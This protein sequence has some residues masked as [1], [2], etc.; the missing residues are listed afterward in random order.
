MLIVYST[1]WAQNTTFKLTDYKNPNYFYQ[2]LDL[3]FDLNSSFSTNKEKSNSITSENTFSMNSG[4]GPIYARYINTA[5]TQTELH[6]K[7]DA[8]I[9]STSHHEKF[10]SLSYQFNTA[11]FS[12]QEGLSITGLRRY[13]NQKQQYFEI[14]GTATI[15][16]NH[17]K[18]ETNNYYYDTVSDQG[19]LNLINSQ[20][21][22]TFL[23]GK[24]RIEQV[25]DARL[26]L[27][28]LDDLRALN[29]EKRMA[30]DEEILA[31]A[32]EIT[33]LKYKRFFDNRLRKI[34]EITAI[35][36]FLQKN[37]LITSADATYFTSLNDNW[38]YAN[39]PVRYSGKRM[40]TGVD[41][42]FKFDH[43]KNFSEHFAPSIHTDEYWQQNTLGSLYYVLGIDYENPR[44]LTWQKSATAKL[45]A[46]IETR[47]L[48][49]KNN[50]SEIKHYL[51]AL[52]GLKLSADYGF[53]YYPNSRTWLTFKWWLLSGWEKQKQGAEKKE[54]NDF[55][56][57]FY[58]YTGPRLNAYYYL[59]ERLRLSFTFNGEFRIDHTKYIDHTNATDLKDLTDTWWN[60][61]L[62]AALAYSLF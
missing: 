11:N 34:A 16:Y 50:T 4:V 20:I 12:H 58:T 42:H 38:N 28:I 61:Q 22:G 57:S 51:Y 26:A 59:S 33:T 14:N 27:Y 17:N 10:D 47:I 21:K 7:F 56:H 23:I 24:G 2:T 54:I 36:E 60:Q 44:S 5:K 19:E 35:D 52:P 62:F 18:Q 15:F 25:Q 31:L 37:G 45:G 49:E 13:Y 9:G 39:N 55:R 29:R 32:Q 48:N 6:A 40:Y 3:Y 30:K 41:A 46:G 8:G 1:T 43:L 53:G